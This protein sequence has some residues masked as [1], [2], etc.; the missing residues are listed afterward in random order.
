[1]LIFPPCGPPPPHPIMLVGFPKLRARLGVGVIRAN[2]QALVQVRAQLLVQ[3]GGTL[4][5]AAQCG[6]RAA[7]LEAER[8]AAV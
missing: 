3:Q 8:E 4:C 7:G 6:V 1:M 5:P 2:P